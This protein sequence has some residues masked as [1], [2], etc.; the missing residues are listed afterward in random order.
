MDFVA[1]LIFKYPGTEWRVGETYESLEWLDTKVEKPTFEELQQAWEQYL[2]EKERNHY[3]KLR[4]AAY[5]SIEDQLD[6]IYHQGLDEWANHIKAVKD[7]YPSPNTKLTQPKKTAMKTQLEELNDKLT[8][9]TEAVEASK[10]NNQKHYVDIGDVKNGIMAVKGF[11][12][13]IPSILKQL[14]KIQ[15]AL[16][17]EKSL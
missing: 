10:I 9:L 13:E 12:I 14:E 8:A 15:A 1:T 11:M 7:K 6:I 5:P 4:A 17:P 3:K 2:F 16:T